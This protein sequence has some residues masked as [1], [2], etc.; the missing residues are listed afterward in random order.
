MKE[1]DLFI[2]SIPSQPVA[3]WDV[4][5]GGALT[6][7]GAVEDAVL[8][9]VSPQPALEAMLPE[10]GEPRVPHVGVGRQLQVVVVE[11]GHVG[12]LQLDRDSAFRLLLVA[13]GHVVPVRPAVAAKGEGK[14]ERQGECELLPLPKEDKKLLGQ[15]QQIP[16]TPSAI[17]LQVFV[18]FNGLQKVSSI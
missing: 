2:G 13:V 7:A 4:P 5:L 18:T 6:G 16:N 10:F 15:L 1:T 8:L 11:P 3:G 17:I 12:R 14:M 9:R